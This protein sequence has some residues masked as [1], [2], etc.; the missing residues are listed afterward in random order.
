[1]SCL[2]VISHGCED[3]EYVDESALSPATVYVAGLQTPIENF[4]ST[5]VQLFLFISEV[6]AVLN[7]SISTY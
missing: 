7:L 2:A 4:S 6:T 3:E 5:H 1:M